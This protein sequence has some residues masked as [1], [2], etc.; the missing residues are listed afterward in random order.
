MPPWSRNTPTPGTSSRKS[1]ADVLA[2][3]GEGMKLELLARGQ[4]TEIG[5]VE[6]ADADGDGGDDGERLA[7]VLAVLARFGLA[8]EARTGGDPPPGEGEAGA[9]R[10]LLG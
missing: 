9:N 2:A 1:Q 7:G 4:A 3:L 5:R 10:P 6:H 8:P